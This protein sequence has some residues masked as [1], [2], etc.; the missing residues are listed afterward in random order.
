MDKLI[1]FFDRYIKEDNSER[2][3]LGFTTVRGKDYLRH[4]MVSLEDRKN[5]IKKLENIRSELYIFN[6]HNKK[7]HYNAALNMLISTLSM[8]EYNDD[9]LYKKSIEYFETLTKLRKIDY[10]KKFPQLRKINV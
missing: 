3:F 10:F 7:E 1:R 2:F 5:Q 8:P 4:E 9:N 6:K